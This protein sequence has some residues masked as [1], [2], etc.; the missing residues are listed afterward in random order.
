MYQSSINDFS[1]QSV[2]Y[3]TLKQWDI[4]IEGEFG[5]S[6]R[7]IDI[8]DNVIYA[9]GRNLDSTDKL[10][11]ESEGVVFYDNADESVTI[12]I[13]I[14]SG[15]PDFIKHNVAKLAGNISP[16]DKDRLRDYMNNI[17]H[18]NNILLFPMDCLADCLVLSESINVNFGLQV[19]IR[20][21]GV[22]LSIG[23]QETV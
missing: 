2:V 23:L 1:I 8:E 7:S 19:E 14:E 11:F 20:T 22:T 9:R 10:F 12:V 6:P 13:P 4:S 5:D 18:D 17:V 21:S 3:Y 15:L 16:K